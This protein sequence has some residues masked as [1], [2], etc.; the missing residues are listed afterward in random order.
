MPYILSEERVKISL[1][2][3]EVEAT[4]KPF[5]TRWEDIPKSC[6]TKTKCKEHKQPVQE[7]EEPVAYVLARLWNNYLPLYDRTDS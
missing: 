2:R 3:S 1:R 7:G 6:M 4:G 5:F